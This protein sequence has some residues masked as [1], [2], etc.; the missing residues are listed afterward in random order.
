MNPIKQRT[1]Q[2]GQVVTHSLSC[3]IDNCPQ[4]CPNKTELIGHLLERHGLKEF[5]CV[6]CLKPGATSKSY[7]TK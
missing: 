2:S 3:F 5:Y 7:D 1:E 6:L 4:V